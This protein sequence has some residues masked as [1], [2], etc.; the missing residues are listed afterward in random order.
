MRHLI[1]IVW[2]LLIVLQLAA[3]FQGMETWLGLAWGWSLLIG[4]FIFGV[5]FG[6]LA[7]AAVGFY[8]AYAGWHWEWWQASLLAFAYVIVTILAIGVGGWVNLF[9]RR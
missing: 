1:V 2:G 7:M 6:Y 9:G 4:T 5:P 8:G 3:F